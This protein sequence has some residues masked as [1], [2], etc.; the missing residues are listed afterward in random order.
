VCLNSIRL[1]IATDV[2][3]AAAIG[4]SGRSAASAI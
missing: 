3:N 2:G 4:A 1:E